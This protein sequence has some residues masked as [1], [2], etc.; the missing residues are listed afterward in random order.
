MNR[1][2]IISF[3][4]R[5]ANLYLALEHLTI[6]S[7]LSTFKESIVRN[8]TIFLHCNSM[9]W[10]TATVS[11]DYFYSE[12]KIWD[13]KIYPHRFNIS[14]P[15]LLKDPVP[16]SDGVINKAFREQFGSGW[17]YRFIF[18]PKPIPANI[19]SLITKAMMQK[20]FRTDQPPMLQSQ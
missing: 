1:F 20:K 3:G 13:D 19:V 17:A 7:S 18:S 10:G 8:S 16:L 2:N 12:E 14:K 4:K 5:Q 9:I 11:S 6:G 15:Q